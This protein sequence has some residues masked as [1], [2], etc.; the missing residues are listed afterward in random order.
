MSASSKD[1][2][3]DTLERLVARALE[4]DERGTDRISL[5][6]AREIALEL[7]ISEAAWDATVAEKVS[8]GNVASVERRRPWV[9][10]RTLIAAIA[11]LAA[12]LLGGWFNRALNGDADV[13]YGVLLVIAGLVV[14]RRRDEETDNAATARLD[15]WW[16]TVPAGLLIALGG[17]KTDPLLFAAFARCGSV[18]LCLVCLRYFA[19]C[20]TSSPRRQH[21]RPNRRCS[22]RRSYGTHGGTRLRSR[23]PRGIV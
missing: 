1:I 17:I 22:W 5:A 9:Q 7:G 2:S 4:L 19:V 10:S 20:A 8:P 23:P 18:G 3:R 16:L 14:S 12:G 21:Q 6:K 15:A 11:G 13:V